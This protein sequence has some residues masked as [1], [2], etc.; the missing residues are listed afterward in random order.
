MEKS[1]PLLNL[2]FFWDNS[3]RSEF[4]VHQNKNQLLKYPNE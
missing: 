1:L 3:G 2:E 4:Q